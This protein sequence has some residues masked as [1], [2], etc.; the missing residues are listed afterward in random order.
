MQH[1]ITIPGESREPR[2]IPEEIEEM[3]RFAYATHDHQARTPP[4]PIFWYRTESDLGLW[5]FWN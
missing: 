3:F 2:L 5:R 4:E 1:V